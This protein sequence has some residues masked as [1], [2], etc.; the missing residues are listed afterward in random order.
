[1]TAGNLITG[2]ISDKFGSRRMLIVCQC[3]IFGVMLFLLPVDSA[4]LLCVFAGVMSFGGGGIG[5][6]E[7]TIIAELFGLKSNS[8]IVGVNFFIFTIGCSSGAFIAGSIFDSAGNYQWAFILCGSLAVAGLIMMVF[9]NQLSKTRT[10][11]AK[12]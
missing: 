4:W 2:L 10:V 7:G 8:V 3:L 11:L 5:V 12:G 1:M 6:L 9:L